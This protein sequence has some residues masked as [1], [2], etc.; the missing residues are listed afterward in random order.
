VTKEAFLELKAK[1]GFVE[2]YA[3]TMKLPSSLPPTD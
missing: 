2:K 1:D 3:P